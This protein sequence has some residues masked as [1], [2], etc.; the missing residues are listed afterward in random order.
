MSDEPGA[1]RGRPS[2]EYDFRR[3]EAPPVDD[4]ASRT[5]AGQRPSPW[6]REQAGQD[7]GEGDDTMAATDFDSTAG[8]DPTA[9]VGAADEPHRF[10]ISSYRAGLYGGPGAE[11]IGDSEFDRQFGARFGGTEFA[12]EF[13]DGEMGSVWELPRD[14]PDG[15][16]DPE[17][18]RSGP[19]MPGPDIPVARDDSGQLPPLGAGQRGEPDN[20]SN[21]LVRPYTRTGGRTRSEYNLAIEALVST[22]AQG[23]RSLGS[24]SPEQQ[25]ICGLCVDTRSVAEVAAHM[26]LPLGVAK[27]LIGDMAGMGLVMVHQ[28]SAV[29]GDRPS[30]EFL[31]RV[32]SGLRRL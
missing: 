21:S 2:R 10:D 9:G 15:Y 24:A 8:F 31:E 1:Q 19:E 20:R 17:P 18:W 6:P 12:R 22:S 30:M 7:A 26:K 27:V 23:M 25:S 32:L 29:V 13:G 11:L 5:D 16:S 4:Q 14:Q 3:W 28:S